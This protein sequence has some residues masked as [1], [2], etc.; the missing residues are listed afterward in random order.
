MAAVSHSTQDA[1]TKDKLTKLASDAYI[2]SSSSGGGSVVFPGGLSSLGLKTDKERHK[3]KR[4]YMGSV[5]GGSSINSIGSGSISTEIKVTFSSVWDALT[6]QRTNEVAGTSPQI[7]ELLGQMLRG[8]V[9]SSGDE[10][11]LL[12][13]LSNV[14]AFGQAAVPH[15]A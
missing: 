8:G 15:L 13:H 4:I 9:M 2:S 12:Q 1:A 5:G 6:G 11:E 7:N 3:D 10:E 14:M